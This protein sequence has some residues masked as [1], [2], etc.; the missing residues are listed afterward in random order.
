MSGTISH[1]DIKNFLPV[2]ISPN[3][4]A[5]HGLVGK[6]CSYYIDQTESIEIDEC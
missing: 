4:Y 2:L 6:I 3:T 5:F 1:V